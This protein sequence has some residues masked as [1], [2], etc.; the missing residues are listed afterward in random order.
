[1]KAVLDACV[2]FPTVLRE[3]LVGVAAK[4][5]YEPLWSDRILREWVLAVRKFGPEAQVLAEGQSVLMKAAFP[6]ACVREQPNIEV[7]VLL[8]DANDHHVLAIA[9]A[10]HADCIV[11]FNAKDFPRH[12]L[13]EEG[14]ERRDPDSLLWQ[15]WSHHPGEVTE[16]VMAVHATAER[17]SGQDLPL[18]AL[19]KR[20][21]LPKLAKAIEGQ[22]A[23]S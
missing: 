19:L 17:L 16:V 9:I 14:I 23:T 21:Q 3:I 6:R 13:A 18:K 5:L 1:M 4:G 10:A 8:P 12:V 11:T 2:I 7:R 22:A 20:A 15:L